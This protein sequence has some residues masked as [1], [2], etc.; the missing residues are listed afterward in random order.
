M[1]ILFAVVGL[2]LLVF[3]HE[4]GHFF[5]ALATRM[6]PR[7]FY[8]GFPPALA[9]LK[10]N[11][12]EYGIGAIPLGGYV[13]IPGMFRPGTRDAQLYLGPAEDEDK[14]LTG[15]VQ[16]LAQSLE[17]GELERAR[18]DLTLVGECLD[19]ASLSPRSSK[20]ARR[21][22]QEIDDSLAP[23]AY[24]R[25]PT[26]KRLV[27]I[28]AGPVTNIL[29]AVL[30]FASLYMLDLYRLGFR[31]VANPKTGATTTQVE[32][33][34]SS[35]PAKRAGLRAGDVV[36][37]VNGQKVTGS[38]LIKHIGASGGRPLTLTVRRYGTLLRLATVKPMN[39][40][41]SLPTALSDSV[42]LTWRITDQIVVNGIGR[43]FVG[44][45]GSNVSGPVGIVKGSSDAYKQGFSDYLF[46]IGLISLS[47][48]VL[49]L[50]PLLPLDGGHIA[51]SLIEGVRGRA[52]SREVYER[53]SA[54]GI[55]LVALLFVLGL[56]ND[57]HHL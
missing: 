28:G 3:V 2:A 14:S 41:E 32:S 29:V 4:A 40:A 10:R 21:G 42:R 7:R 17:Q 25:Q 24:W 6:R 48:G 56:S 27:V 35:S 33:V 16:A 50:L 11:G 43:L 12:I 45:G 39:E 22:L 47:L 49:N 55:A 54:F 20:F 19:G 38:T 18:V 23:D 51:F 44:R 37:A 9:K 36:V 31:V 15:P 13:K 46:V 1:S 57:V 53:V 34:L 52:V 30:I 26:W 5:V 8:I